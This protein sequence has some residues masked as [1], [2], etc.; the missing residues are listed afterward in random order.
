MI[1]GPVVEDGSVR[2]C[3]DK[4]E[5][6]IDV[7]AF[8]KRQNEA[9]ENGK[10]LGLGIASYIEPSGGGGPWS[11]FNAYESARV[12]MTTDGT[13]QVF[14]GNM[15]CGQGVET[16]LAQVTADRLGCSY[17]RVSVYCG[18]TDT[19]P[20]G[21]GASA[22]RGVVIALGAVVKATDDLIEKI[23]IV[24]G[25]LLEV[26][27]RDLV[28]G[29]DAVM[30]KGNPDARVTLSAVANAAFLYPGGT[31]SMPGVENPTLEAVGIYTSPYARFEPDEHGR[32]QEYACHATGAQAAL[33][34]VDV[35]TGF[36]TVDEI[37]I[38][39][40]VGVVINPAGLDGQITGGTIQSFAGAVL[41]DH[42]Y[43]AKGNPL[44]TTLRDYGF[45]N[46]QSVPHVRVEHIVTPGSTTPIG[47][48]G[49]GEGG[50]I[51]TY[52]CIMSAVEDALEPFG[53]T[54]NEL[55]LAPWKI[56]DL[57][58]NDTTRLVDSTS[59]KGK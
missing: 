6:I 25:Q 4:L 51:A 22:S 21:M 43:D 50:Q 18:D 7:P 11:F 59:T 20:Y 41:E 36:V 49:A 46:I 53:V 8:R 10:Y 45:P 56:L 35:T 23:L 16:T 28:L 48:K 39:G 42:A 33:V 34:E 3:L 17:H 1:T 44:A 37:V 24:A 52:S 29:D 58:S 57:V 54:V 2:E 9:R 14:T 13:V 5:S 27:P 38:V 15:R 40:D 55:P 47:A 12:R 19:M 31:V 32:T 26:S 30:V